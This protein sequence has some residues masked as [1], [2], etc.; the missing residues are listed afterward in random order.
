MTGWGDL[1]PETELRS[2]MWMVMAR[3]IELQNKSYELN[4]AIGD[5]LRHKDELD[6][7]ARRILSDALALSEDVSA[8]MVRARDLLAEDL[9]EGRS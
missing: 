8:A 4:A 7:S 5:A 2:V 6:N 9:M 1:R 3:M